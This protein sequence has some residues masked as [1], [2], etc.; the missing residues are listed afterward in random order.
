[1]QKSR[2]PRPTRL[3]R[4]ARG[5]LLL[6]LPL[7]GLALYSPAQ[8]QPQVT[9]PAKAAPSLISPEDRTALD[10][11]LAFDRYE[12]ICK[13]PIDLELKDATLPDVIEA[14]QD[15]FPKEKIV[16][17]V[18]DA[19]SLRVSFQVK[20][21]RVGDV[22]QSAAE[23]CGCDLYIFE[24]SLL[25]AR[26]TS[27]LAG[28]QLSAS[29]GRSGLWVESTAFGGSSGWSNQ[30]VAERIF[31]Q[32]IANEV[33]TGN[34]TPD[35]KGV[36]NTTFSNF[37][38]EAQGMLQQIGS[39]IREDSR[40][41]N[42]NPTPFILSPDSPVQVDTSDPK[43]V[44]IHLRGGPSNPEIGIVGASVLLPRK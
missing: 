19:N 39:W 2:F 40:S 4:R 13:T 37:S 33:A 38:P 23:L 25:I 22:L 18:R 9:P 26:P 35:G 20:Q 36:V 11:V 6:A 34:F 42:P 28:Q 27:L 8:A 12:S 7:C 30:S 44:K 5:T 17:N 24:D 43:R 21:K 16:I 3:V 29:E 10:R 15:K 31:A 41:I 32:A 1:M 14:I